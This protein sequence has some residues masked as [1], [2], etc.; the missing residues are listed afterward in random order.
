M[1]IDN[2]III[3]EFSDSIM[4]FADQL[5]KKIKL[6]SGGSYGREVLLN[7]FLRDYQK[8]MQRKAIS[9]G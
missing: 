7:F 8:N 2:N 5:S 6:C 3:N 1:C 4:T 9:N